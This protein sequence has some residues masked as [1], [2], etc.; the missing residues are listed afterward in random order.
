[1]KKMV[2]AFLAVSA[3]LFF[4][5]DI[6]ARDA[7]P[8]MPL[9]SKEESANRTIERSGLSTDVK[10][11]NAKYIAT[12]TPQD[13]KKSRFMSSFVPNDFMPAAQRETDKKTN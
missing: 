9:S 7:S 3:I 4:S 6:L 2:L 8:N 13:V 11:A 1:M 5:K 12:I 10:P